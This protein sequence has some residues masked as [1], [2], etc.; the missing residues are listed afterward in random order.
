VASFVSTIPADEEIS[1]FQSPISIWARM[2]TSILIAGWGNKVLIEMKRKL[3]DMYEQNEKG[4][5]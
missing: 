2:T 1:S 5:S 4:K 3:K